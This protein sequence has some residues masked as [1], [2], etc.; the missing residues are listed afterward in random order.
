MESPA[1]PVR[2]LKLRSES[3]WWREIAAPAT[4]HK[5][6]TCNYDGRGRIAAAAR[7]G[8]RYNL[9]P[10]PR[11]TFA[12]GMDADG[13]AVAAPPSPPRL[14]LVCRHGVVEAWR[15]PED[16]FLHHASS[17]VEVTPEH[18]R[19]ACHT[20]GGF[21]VRRFFDEVIQ[22]QRPGYPAVFMEASTPWI[23]YVGAISV[24]S[25]LTDADIEA[26]R[27]P[28]AGVVATAW[29]LRLSMPSPHFGDIAEHFYWQIDYDTCRHLMR[30][31]PLLD[32]HGQL[33][34]SEQTYR[35]QPSPEVFNPAHYDG[36]TQVAHSG[37]AEWS[38]AATMCALSIVPLE[39][40]CQLAYTRERLSS[41]QRR[42]VHRRAPL[43]RT[44]QEL[45]VDLGRFRSQ[46][47]RNPLQDLGGD[48]LG[49]VVGSLVESPCAADWRALLRFRQTCRAARDAV[50][51]TAGNFVLECHRLVSGPLVTPMPLTTVFAH[52]ARL[53]AAGIDAEAVA[54]EVAA[55]RDVGPTTY[56]HGILG[57]QS[58]RALFLQLGRLRHPR[59]APDA[60]LPIA[61]TPETPEAVAVE[62]EP[63]GVARPPLLLCGPGSPASPA[64]PELQLGAPR[65]ARETARARRKAQARLRQQD[66]ARHHFAA[67][68]PP[69]SPRALAVHNNVAGGDGDANAEAQCAQ[70]ARIV[71]G[72]IAATL[73]VLKPLED[74]KRPPATRARTRGALARPKRPRR[75]PAAPRGSEEG[76]AACRCAKSPR[77]S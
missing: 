67:T 4:R 25:T 32:P 17:A 43:P 51:V 16:R 19:R 55:R 40:P 72:D 77:S 42:L 26:E 6:R 18:W 61:A 24:I 2:T 75:A 29:L 73:N 76:G 14:I 13:P 7:G 3:L 23:P 28:E 47:K 8:L 58:A 69:L 66:D 56:R 27:M 64:T 71:A 45:S 35:C 38:R 12:R 60:H 50:D 34:L 30:R 70:R 59:R 41:W 33:R 39:S 22:A 65:A 57:A 15:I 9:H 31:M 36:A 68:R 10:P 1:P 49:L 37:A 21:S 48:V 63:A 74:E 20:R 54:C 46:P 53:L 44:P 11:R 5:L 62:W 52:G